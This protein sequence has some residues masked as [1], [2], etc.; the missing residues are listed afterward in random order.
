[1]DL[2]A[3]VLLVMCLTQLVMTAFIGKL[4]VIMNDIKDEKILVTKIEASGKWV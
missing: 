4:A 1:M 2:T 3:C